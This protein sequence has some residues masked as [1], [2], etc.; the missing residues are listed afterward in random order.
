VPIISE[1]LEADKKAPKKQ[2]H[3]A[4]RILERLRKEHGYIGG[5]TVVQ[6]EVRRWKQRSAEVFMPLTHRPG[7]VQ[8]DF[9]TATVIY[10][11]QERKV[12]FS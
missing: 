5:H 2:R 3:T 10:R 12:S 9:G 7:E 11:G 4:K 1:I 6:E 8:A